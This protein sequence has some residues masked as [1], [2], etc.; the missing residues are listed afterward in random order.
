[1]ESKMSE[2]DLS[3]DYLGMKLRTPLV[4]SASPLSEEVDK[5]KRL[6]DAGASAVVLHSLF[7]EQLTR[8]KLELHYHLETYSDAIAEAVTFIPEPT[9]F[10]VGPDLYL[11]HIR[12]AKE[13][14][15]IPIIAS[16]N[17]SHLGQWTTFAGQLEE[18]GAD[19]VELNIYNVPT[20]IEHS[21]QAIE[22]EV[23]QI[24]QAVKGELNVPVAVKLSPFFTNMAHMANRLAASGADGLVLFN[25]FYQP[26]IDLELLE[27]YPHV[28]L[29]EPHELRLPL[30]WIAILHGAVN[31][32][33]AATTGVHTALDVLKLLMVG[34]NVTMMASALL[35]NGIDHLTTVEKELLEWMEEHEYASVQMMQGSMSHRNVADPSAF[36]RVHYVQA[37][38][39]YPR[40]AF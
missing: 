37:L 13:A 40:D 10:H 34:A 25:R 30:R 27:T 4:P 28:L 16:L 24:V 5:I 35:R 36:E 12:Q 31:V 32:D 2:I 26:D 3:T 29:S 15:D 8:D 17:G 18:A 7:A 19:A 1:M 11:D 20:E 6:E 14:V 38:Q 39:T 21:S 9:E 23:C 33:L 22:D